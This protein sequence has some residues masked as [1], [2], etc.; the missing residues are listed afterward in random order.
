[1]K[2]VLSVGE[3]A[4]YLGVHL[5]T[6]RRWE[7]EGTLKPAERTPGGQRRYRIAG[8]AAFNPQSTGK[9]EKRTLAYARVSSSDQKADQ[10]LAG[11]RL[12][13]ADRWFASF[14]TCSACDVKS[15]QRMTLD[16]REWTCEHCGTHHH[17]DINAATN[18]DK[19]NTPGVP[20]CQP[21]ESSP[22]LPGS[23]NADRQAASVKQEPDSHP[24]LRIA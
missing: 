13:V 24:V 5:G 10:A 6:M 22:P 11:R 7:R 8:L 20:R 19:S 17:R 14:K 1:M 4:E 12:V 21:V 3:A 16:V 18:P 15:E 23:G 9:P 2:Q